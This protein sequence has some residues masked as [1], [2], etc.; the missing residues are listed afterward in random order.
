MADRVPFPGASSTG[1]RRTA[2]LVELWV[3]DAIEVPCA[4]GL[5]AQR[6]ATPYTGVETLASSIVVVAGCI[7][8]H[9]SD[10]RRK[11]KVKADDPA[12]CTA[13]CMDFGALQAWTDV[14]TEM[15]SEV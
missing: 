6:E 14:Y 2:G 4:D 13:G 15:L 5:T 7:Y 8:P 12:I 3:V 11:V 1:A 9:V 10:W